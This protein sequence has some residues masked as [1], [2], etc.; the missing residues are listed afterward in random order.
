MTGLE[1]VLVKAGQ[2][3]VVPAV[4]R[5]L[6]DRQHR[7]EARLPLSE[8]LNRRVTDGFSR[9]KLEREIQALADAVAQRLAPLEQIGDMPEHERRAAL[10]AVATA[11]S[12]VANSDLALFG[13]DADAGR[14]AAAIRSGAADVPVAAGLGEAGWHLYERALDEC[15]DLYVQTVIHL[16]TFVP[17]GI[18]QV[19]AGITGLGE[20]LAQA[21]DRL[22]VRTLDAPAGTGEDELFRHRYLA[23]VSSALDVAELFGVDVRR[24]R[25]RTT[26]NVAYIS[27]AVTSDESAER[28]AVTGSRDQRW[29]PGSLR[30]SSADSDVGDE[31]NLVR[32]EQALGRSRRTLLRGEAG[33]GKTTVLR[34]L[35]VNAA[36]GAFS[37]ELATWNTHV[38]FLVVLRRYTNVPLPTPD[39]LVAATVDAIAG[40]APPSWAHRQLASGQALLLVDGVDEVPAPARRGVR[41][42]LQRITSA[43]PDIAVVVTSRPPA[44]AARWLSSEG[45]ASTRLERM[46][47]ADMRTLITHWHRAIAQAGDLPCDVQDLPGYENEL[48][49]RLD[50]SA[51]LHALATSP[52]LCAMLCAL[53]LDRRRHLPLDRMSLYAAAVDLLLER[54]DVERDI[55][56]RISGRDKL[57]LLQYLAGKMSLN[58]EAETTREAVLARL[59][60][61]LAAMS[62]VTAEPAELLEDLLQRSGLLRQPVPDRIDFVHRTFQ[63]YLTAREAA[64]RADIGMLVEKAHRESWRDVVVMAVG[65]A[66]ARVRDDLIGQI[67]D[68][69][70]AEPARCRTLRLLAAACLETAP[71]LAPALLNRIHHAVETLLPPRNLVEARS[72]AGAGEPLLHHLPSVTANL[73]PA[74]AAA[75]VRTA[76]LINGPG[77]MTKLAQYAA[78]ARTRVQRELV[79]AWEYFDPHEYAT[80]VLADA[81]LDDGKVEITQPQ[82]LP[83]I[84][85]LQHLRELTVEAREP[86]DLAELNEVPHLRNL[87]LWRGT[88]SRLTALQQHDDLRLL[89]VMN[90]AEVADPAD[91]ALLP[92]LAVLFVFHH[93][94]ISNLD[95]LHHLPRLERLG[96]GSVNPVNDFTALDHL[97][98]L[99]F[100]SL[101]GPQLDDY[102]PLHVLNR[103]TGLALIDAAEPT[104]GLAGV[105]T[106]APNLDWLRIRCPWVHDLGN[107]V[108]LTDLRFLDVSL[109]PIA[110]LTPLIDLPRLE[111]VVLNTCP[112]LSDLTPLA[113]LPNL[114]YLD[115]RGAPRD[116]DLSPLSEHRHLTIYLDPGQHVRGT[117]Q[118][119]PRTRLLHLP[120]P[121][122]R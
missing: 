97:P 64:D 85:H 113:Q 98:A 94:G 66:N 51:H 105:A 41:D 12:R 117:D 44:A 101:V 26:L 38:P 61:K 60:D 121:L 42:W 90:I 43:Y 5:W 73:S 109:T 80:R 52:L 59:A 50:A 99:D 7:E 2:A 122:A 104:H 22:P 75:T 74:A 112:N 87:Q 31:T 18:A 72:L 45:F 89:R 20:Q 103:L 55:P 88:P 111:D 4:K 48:V 57:Q 86:L 36:R 81:A 100:L 119:K 67:L 9:R 93:P 76:A 30:R 79:R 21:L 108:S 19:L 70:E 17:R 106:L 54:R 107:L 91:T 53:N 65:H 71:A 25:P 68:R 10:D 63:E 35:A 1:S 56:I 32:I 69:S 37:A 39:Q 28:Q 77:A 47:P 116:L 13:A 27:L 114:K 46:S 84:R 78:D 95:F 96:L 23:Q 118:L 6:A 115:L 11:F 3:V 58:N 40:Q 82:L 110:D 14:L 33:S 29:L 24:Y 120:N 49:G 102:T 16:P 83:A 62:Q 92:H 8:L 15:C 34:W